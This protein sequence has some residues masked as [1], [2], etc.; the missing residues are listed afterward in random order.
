[1]STDWCD[2][3]TTILTVQS[4]SFSVRILSGSGF[5]DEIAKLSVC[6]VS[7]V[8]LEEVSVILFT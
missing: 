3:H 5:G 2:G 1:M 6:V 7:F 4:S 8:P